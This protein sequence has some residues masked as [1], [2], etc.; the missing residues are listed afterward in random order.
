MVFIRNDIIFPANYEA[1]I[2]SKYLSS[3]K[4]H[5]WKFTDCARKIGGQD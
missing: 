5:V 2:G 1:K 3:E 4:V